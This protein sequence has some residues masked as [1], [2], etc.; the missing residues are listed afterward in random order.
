[1][2]FKWLTNLKIMSHEELYHPPIKTLVT[3]RQME[4][5]SAW[6]SRSICGRLY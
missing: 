1:M 2:L 6:E 5:L 3:L 4:K